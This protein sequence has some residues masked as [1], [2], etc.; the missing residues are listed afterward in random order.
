MTKGYEGKA[1]EVCP[2]R[3]KGQSMLWCSL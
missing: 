3:C 1:K 2:C